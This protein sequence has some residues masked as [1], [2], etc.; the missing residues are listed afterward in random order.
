MTALAADAWRNLSEDDKRYYRDRLAEGT[1]KRGKPSPLA[2]L[3]PGALALKHEPLLTMERPHLEVIDR[4]LVDVL[5]TPRAKLMIFT[6]PQVGKSARVSRWFP[7]WWLTQR[8]RDRIILGS[9][10]STLAAGHSAAA[11][12]YVKAY[13]AEYG[14][15]LKDDEKTRADWTTTSGGGVRARGVRSGLTGNPMDLG[16]IDDPLADRAAAESLVIREAVWDWY[17]SAFLS[18]MAPGGKQILVMTR[19]HQEDLAGKLLKRD[20]R[21]EDGGE[22]TVVHLPALAMP[23]DHERGFYA[24]PLGRAPGEPLTHP[25]IDVD[26]TDGMTRHWFT[27]R[28]DMGT[29]DFSALC[30]GSPV[31]VEGGLVKE[32]M[33]QDRTSA[34][35]GEAKRSGVGIDPSGGGRD[36]AGI[37]G[38][39]VDNQGHLWWTHSRTKRMSADEWPREACLLAAEIDADRI[40]YESNYGGDMAGSLIKQAWKSLQE[41]GEIGARKMCPMITGVHS[42]KSKTLRAEPIAAA[43]NAGRAWFTTE[44]SLGELKREW[45]LWEVG[46]TW[47]PGALDAAV[48]LAYELLPAI[49]SGAQTHSVASRKKGETTGSSAVSRRRRR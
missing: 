25:K 16:L 28:K 3:T 34:T 45:Q 11:R 24:D 5:T 37:I 32:Q 2:P 8:P 26:D 21:V 15:Q 17:T 12:D 29:R 14:L 39:H 9:Y 46:S 4:A 31:N 40:V 36:T 18:R 30:Q 22:W 6:P 7:F 42:R 13:G 27:Q 23:E 38:G 33:I 48:H 19:W 20:G 47:S 41:A 35:P 10:A 44:P 49:G 43:V 1:A